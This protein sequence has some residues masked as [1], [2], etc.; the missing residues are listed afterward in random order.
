MKA[1]D[2][3]RLDDGQPFPCEVFDTAQ[4]MY[5]YGRPIPGAWCV[6]LVY[7]PSSSPDVQK[8]MS[9]VAARNGLQPPVL[10]GS[11]ELHDEGEP[12]ACSTEIRRCMV[13]FETVNA[14]K[15]WA[16]AHPGRAG[17]GIIFGDTAKIPNP[18][19]TT[20][21]AQVITSSLD[22]VHIQ[23]TRCGTIKRA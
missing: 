9:T 7:A 4:G 21:T 10:M 19:G 5:G 11:S 1:T 18:D 12:S 13:G 20:D 17:L 15:T 6:P 16:A 3:K 8:I 14:L 2:I 23:G 22:P